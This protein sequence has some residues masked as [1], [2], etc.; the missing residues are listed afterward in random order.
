MN[1]K[2]KTIT[3]RL[4]VLVTFETPNPSDIATFR[5]NLLDIPQNAASNGMMSQG[6]EE[7]VVTSWDARVDTF[8]PAQI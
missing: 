1:P 8:S 3:L 5:Q 2:M 7:G 6:S 4:T